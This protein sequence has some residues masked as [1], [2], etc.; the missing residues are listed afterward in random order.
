MAAGTDRQMTLTMFMTAF[1]YHQDAWRHPSSRSDEIGGLAMIRD[2]AQAAE[3][4]KLDAIFI[5][6]SL[7]AQPFERA[8]YRGVSVYEPVVTL[9]ALIGYTDE[10]G[11]LG[12]QST[13]F[14]EPYTVARQFAELDVLSGGRAGWNIVT[15]VSGNENYGRELP[16]KD[17]RYD[18]ATEF[19]DV[20]KK[21]WD[22]WDADAVVND[23]ARGFWVDPDRIHR[24]DHA[25]EHFRVEGPLTIPR[26]PQ[27][28]PVLVQ[29]GQSPAG[30]ELG[31]S[32]GDLIYTVQPD[33]DEAVAFYAA[34]KRKVADKGRNPEKVRILP[35]IMPI[36]GRTQKEAEDLAKELEDCIH[37][38]TGRKMLENFV[39]FDVSD[40]ELGDR[41][42]Q[43]RFVDD[44]EKLERWKLFRSLAEERTVRELMVHLARAVGHRVI[45]STPERIA[46]T[47]IDWFDS[48]A[49]DGYNLN[50]PSVPEGMNAVFDLLVPE[51][52]ERGYFRR[53][54]VGATMRERSG[55]TLDDEVG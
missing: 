14:N 53:E 4:A 19:V 47:M 25:G 51:L 8:S 48:R 29:A 2:M 10:I 31:T 50:M 37:E 42:P 26:S 28:R 24:I 23:R 20:V 36:T 38:P 16:P 6:D 12:T 22:S 41:I 49:C 7:T 34:Y 40:L 27:Q 13:T 5:A 52:Q 54:Y 3:R 33:K 44:G 15:S 43:E 46:D 21:L 11:L 55:L 30:I 9:A 35:G 18:R 45:V 32:V 39:G 1:G 17:W